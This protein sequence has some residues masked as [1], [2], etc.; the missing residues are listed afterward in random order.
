MGFEDS[1]IL[2]MKMLKSVMAQ[3]DNDTLLNEIL[4]YLDSET[5]IDCMDY[6]T[7]Q[8]DLDRLWEDNENEN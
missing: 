8:W 4:S 3:L 6:I 7:T 2:S 1:F 5:I